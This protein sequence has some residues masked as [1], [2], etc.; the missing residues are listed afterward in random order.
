LKK[1]SIVIVGGAFDPPHIG[2]AMAIG[3]VRRLFACDEIWLMPSADRRDKSIVAE[4]W[5]RMSMVRRMREE[6]FLGRKKRVRVSAVELELGPPSTTH[7]TLS[8][9]SKTYPNIEFHFLVGSDV[10]GD[11]ETRWFRGPALFRRARFI[12]I[13]R[14]GVA[15]PRRLPPHTTVIGNTG[16]ATDVSSSVVRDFAKRGMPLTPYV[17]RRVEVYIRKNKLY[18]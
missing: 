15:L 16:S 8:H 7:R 1:K 18:R 12:V 14:K 9:L 11:I 17:T 2:H 3:A 4:K 5:H 13:K 10:V 6:L